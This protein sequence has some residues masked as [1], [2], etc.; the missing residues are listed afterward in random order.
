[1]LSVEAAVASRPVPRTIEACVAN[2]VL[3]G[4]HYTYK[5]Y[6]P[7]R[8]QARLLDL[9]AFE[10]MTLRVRGDLLPGDLLMVKSIEVIAETCT[11]PQE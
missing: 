5:L 10:G 3:A 6:V 7:T 2:G 8:T 1:M 9:A 11:L 4:A